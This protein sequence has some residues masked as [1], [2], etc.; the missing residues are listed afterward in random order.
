MQHLKGEYLIF[1]H[2]IN[3]AAIPDVI[4]YINDDDTINFLKKLYENRNTI[5]N[6]NGD[7]LKIWSV[8]KKYNLCFEEPF[9]LC[10]EKY[11][12]NFL[13]FFCLSNYGFM[14][15]YGCQY[16]DVE[17]AEQFYDN[18]I[19][20]DNKMLKNIRETFYKN[21]LSVLQTADLLG[22]SHQTIKDYLNKAERRMIHPSRCKVVR[23]MMEYDPQSQNLQRKDEVSEEANS[24]LKKALSSFFFDNGDMP[25]AGKKYLLLDKECFY[26]DE[27]EEFH[28]NIPDSVIEKISASVKKMTIE[29]L[30]MSVRSFNCLKR[31]GINTVD[32]LINKSDEEMMK[33]RNLGKKSFDEVREKLASLDIPF[34]KLS[35]YAQITYELNYNQRLSLFFLLNY[36]KDVGNIRICNYYSDSDNSK[37]LIDILTDNSS[38]DYQKIEDNSYLS[39][40]YF[41]SIFADETHRNNLS[42][43]EKEVFV[44]YIYDKFFPDNF[45]ASDHI[46][47]GLYSVLRK[48]GYSDLNSAIEDNADILSIEDLGNKL[49][50]SDDRM[51]LLELYN[52]IKGHNN[53]NGTK[54][55]ILKVTKSALK[56]LMKNDIRTFTSLVVAYLDDFKHFHF[57]N[58][59]IREEV[60]DIMSTYGIKKQDD[61]FDLTE[62]LFNSKINPPKGYDIEIVRYERGNFLGGNNGQI[63]YVT[64]KNKKRKNIIVSVTDIYLI[65]DNEQIKRTF[66]LSG[67]FMSNEKISPKL[68]K[69]AA[70]IFFDNSLKNTDLRYSKIGVV[71]R[72]DNDTED[73]E[74][75]FSYDFE[76]GCW[77]MISCDNIE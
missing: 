43:D 27:D 35:D 54:T 28:F 55:F 75:V 51:T 7:Y 18:N 13:F 63:V 29:E 72:V 61:S 42:L 66:W 16:V 48:S 19:F 34:R 50:I 25:I 65:Q 12:Y 77:N 20:S 24:A 70:A 31:A 8:L 49:K 15:R 2:H 44:N 33:V 64:I 74:F 17:K 62:Y 36:L 45:S 21:D 22:Y 30:D 67:Y 76:N 56:F 6:D 47:T 40:K 10:Y 52:T 60:K 73:R 11:P 57:H 38:F 26:I 9:S 46:S 59:Q 4:P 58:D 3:Y 23:R 5:F 53:I 14:A 69:T 68:L 1:R 39:N 37:M 41:M 71:L 32:D